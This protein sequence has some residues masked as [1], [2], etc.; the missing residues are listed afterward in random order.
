MTSLRTTRDLRKQDVRRL[1]RGGYEVAYIETRHLECGDE[2][3][4]VWTRP[5]RAEDLAEHEIPF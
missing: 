5:E 1:K 4:V 3:A 2:T